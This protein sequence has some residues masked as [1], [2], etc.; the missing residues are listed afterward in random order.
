MSATGPTRTC[1]RI[2]AFP[3]G[4]RR[5]SFR[6]TTQPEVADVPDAEQP[7]ADDEG[8]VAPPERDER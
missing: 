6:R 3:D 8:H 2:R 7:D 4:R 5:S 1:R